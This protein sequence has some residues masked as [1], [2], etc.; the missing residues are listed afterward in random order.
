[1][2]DEMG[3][4]RGYQMKQLTQAKGYLAV[5]LSQ[6]MS[7]LLAGLCH[8][9]PY[10]MV[11]LDGSNLN[12]RR[13]TST[14]DN[15]QQLTAYFTTNGKGKPNVSVLESQLQ[16]AVGKPSSCAVVELA[17]MPLTETGEIDIGLLRESNLGRST[18]ER[19]KPRNETEQQIAQIWQ[20][21]LEV[22]QV[23]IYDNF[24]ELGG[25][26]LLATQVI[27]RL[28]QAFGKE[29][30]LQDL[31][32]YPTVAGITKNIEVLRQL[33]QKENTFIYETDEDY[34]EEAL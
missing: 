32:E 4:S 15:L 3:M 25:N 10:L 27:S 18:Q 34:E 2:W 21:L 1:M 20:D 19:V 9:Q 11:G 17:E 30:T 13:L 33:A 24:F 28:R 29:L 14:S 23:G 6:G 5:G 26:S 8:D 7:S 22:S 12:I 31:F 16:D